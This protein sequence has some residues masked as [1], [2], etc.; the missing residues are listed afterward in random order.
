M[1]RR[2]RLSPREH[3]Q[4]VNAAFDLLGIPQ[5][6]S[7]IKPKRVVAAPGSDGRPL[8]RNVLRDVMRALRADPRVASVERNQSGVYQS[9]ERWVT[10]GSRGKLD[11]TVYLRSGRYMEVEVKRD[12]HTKPSERQAERIAHIKREGGIAG[13]CWDAESALRLLPC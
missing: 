6:K 10:V 9:G 3:K 4:A 13:W 11:L 12:R 5:F 2:G 7:E 8:E 1:R